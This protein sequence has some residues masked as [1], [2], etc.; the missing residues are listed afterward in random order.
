MNQSFCKLTLIY[1][2][3][4]EDRLVDLLL[5]IEPPL[6]GFTSWHAEGHGAGFSQT[7]TNEQV[8]GRIGR[9]MV[10]LVIARER[11]SSFLDQMGAL[12]ATPN[13]EYWVE[14][15]EHFGHIR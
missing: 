12:S 4:S 13:L 5:E 3:A 1:P 11:L 10:V 15:V 7:S 6:G 8:R 9:G 2:L 14:P